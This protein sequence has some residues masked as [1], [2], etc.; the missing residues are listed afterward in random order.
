MMECQLF[1]TDS[2]KHFPVHYMLPGPDSG[3]PLSLLALAEVCM[4]DGRYLVALIKEIYLI[5]LTFQ[6]GDAISY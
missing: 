1:A 5:G 2:Q 3:S 6:A 4:N